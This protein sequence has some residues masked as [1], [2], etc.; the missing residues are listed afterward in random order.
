MIRLPAARFDELDSELRATLQP[1]GFAVG[2]RE[3]DGEMGSH[4]N[5]YNRG[6]ERV[7]LH[8]NPRDN[9]ICIYYTKDVTVPKPSAV[10]LVS[11]PLNGKLSRDITVFARQLH[12]RLE[13]AI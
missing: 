2:T 9:A 13:H 7:T 6:N 4:T 11:L 10:V 5:E 12:Q 8:W 3:R 1:R